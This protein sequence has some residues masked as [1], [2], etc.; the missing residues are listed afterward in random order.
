MKFSRSAFNSTA[1]GR[2][3][4]V[5]GE[6]RAFGPT[7][8]MAAL[9]ELELPLWVDSRRWRSA[10]SANV[11]DRLKTRR[12]R[13]Q[14]ADPIADIRGTAAASEGARRRNAVRQCG[15]TRHFASRLL[16]IPIHII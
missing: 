13:D 14:N 12:T 9:R 8:A 16:A 5:S 3:F 10:P 7:L 6:R 11:S 4:R 1:S 2:R 15:Y